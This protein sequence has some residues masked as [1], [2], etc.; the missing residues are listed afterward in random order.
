MK[1]RGWGKARVLDALP[2]DLNSADGDPSVLRPAGEFDRGG[3]LVRTGLE[4]GRS[5]DVPTRHAPA[6][7]GSGVNSVELG[8]P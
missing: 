8:A 6:S 2:F 5:T 3:A 1:A 7:P 4:G